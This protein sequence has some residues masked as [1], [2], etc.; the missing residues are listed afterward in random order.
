LLLQGF[1][2]DIKQPPS[3]RPAI[4][5]TK[6]IEPSMSI[7]QITTL[8]VSAISQGVIW[9]IMSLGVYI[10][11]RL[12]AFSDLTVDGSFT[13]GGALS[14]LL[15]VLG[16]HPLV[17]L[18]VAAIGGMIAG[19]VTG[20]LNTR[21]GIS[22]LLSSILTQIGLYSI[23]LKIMGKPNMPL[24]RVETLFTKFN[25]L[26]GLKDP[27]ASLLLGLLFAVILV[28]FLYW[29]F[30]TEIGCAVRATGNNPSMCRALG[31][32]TRNTTMLALILGNGLVALSGGLLA[33]NQ[34]YADIGMGTGAIVIGL[35]T[36]IIG[37]VIFFKKNFILKLFGVV[38]GSIVYR[39]VIAVVLQLNVQS[40]DLKLYTAIIVALALWIPNAVESSRRKHARKAAN[41]MIFD[42][43][44]E[45]TASSPEDYKN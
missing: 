13:T 19:F 6:G 27:Y 33:Q 25:D 37:E 41:A 23:N 31:V 10:T 28:I 21:M 32:N 1:S 38:F 4:H 26:T 18:F 36:I 3:G 16:Y 45:E 43:P 9:S 44:S 24:L 14:A 7:D 8:A 39:I 22:P 30:G 34:G 17:A 5:L 11:Y 40:Q 42:A 35:A 12:L 15:I 20:F 2:L 29:F